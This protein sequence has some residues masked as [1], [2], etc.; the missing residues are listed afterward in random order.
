M[1]IPYIN[2]GRQIQTEGRGLVN[3]NS[4]PGPSNTNWGRGP[5]PGLGAGKHKYP[6]I[7]DLASGWLIVE[8]AKIV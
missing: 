8:N 6:R 4:G 3:T 1:L 7:H 5:G 2:Q